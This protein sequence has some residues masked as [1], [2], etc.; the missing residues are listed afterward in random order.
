MKLINET[1]KEKLRG[2]FYTPNAIAEF[3]LKWG[4]NGNEENDVLE[5][6]CGDGVFL[7]EIKNGNYKYKRVTAVEID[8]IEAEKTRKISLP[9]SNIVIA[10]FHEFCLKTDQK[11][12][13][14]IGNPPYI[15]Y[16]F[17][18][19]KQQQIAGNIFTK[20]HL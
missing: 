2:G 12:D 8:P 4:F 11:F 16:Q 15:R 3:I 19:R 7:E 14:V 10:D 1:T 20:A 17:F 9:K 13:L 18:D 5:P 6:S